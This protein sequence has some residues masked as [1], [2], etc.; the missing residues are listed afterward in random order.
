MNLGVLMHWFPSES[1]TQNE[2]SFSLT[3]S[4][5]H[6]YALVCGLIILPS[7]TWVFL[8]LLLCVRMDIVLVLPL[9]VLLGILFK[10][11]HDF[12]IQLGCTF[13]G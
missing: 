7:L 8:E 1:S 3:L 4:H 12:A 2:V 11:N 5:A 10:L 13:F 6:T 9:E